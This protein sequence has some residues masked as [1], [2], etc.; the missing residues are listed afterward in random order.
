MAVGRDLDRHV[1]AV[2]QARRLHRLVYVLGPVA[3]GGRK[4]QRRGVRP[5]LRDVLEAALVTFLGPGVEAQRI[6]LR[7]F[8]RAEQD[9]GLLVVEQP[10]G[11][12]TMR[13]LAA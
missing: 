1:E 12:E 11:P 7:R 3:V 8:G 13:L 9:E 5:A 4:A 6:G 2:A 10:W